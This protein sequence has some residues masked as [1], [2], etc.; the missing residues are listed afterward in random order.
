MDP[1]NVCKTS[2]VGYFKSDS[3]YKRSKN[4]ARC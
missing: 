3:Q 4:I 1:V 2:V